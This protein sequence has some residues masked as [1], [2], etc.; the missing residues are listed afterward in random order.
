MFICL[1]LISAFCAA[2]TVSPRQAALQ[3]EI[4]EIYTTESAQ[5]TKE[6]INLGTYYTND[7]ISQVVE[8]FSKLCREFD[9]LDCP[10]AYFSKDNNSIVAM[11]PNK[12]LII[13][14]KVASKLSTNELTFILA[15]EFK[16]FKVNDT[17]QKKCCT[18]QFCH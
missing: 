7:N 2:N 5:D 16:H 13:S 15:H 14:E 8:I 3:Q 4:Y 6:K 17:Y 18:S 10:T 12:V 9:V 11:L 1:S